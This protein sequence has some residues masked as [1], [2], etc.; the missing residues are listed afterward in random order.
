MKFPALMSLCSSSLGG[1]NI[2]SHSELE[3]NL[4]SPPMTLARHS[5]Y[6]YVV[7]YFGPQNSICFQ[8]LCLQHPTA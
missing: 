7:C 6:H 8:L 2:F 4:H 1:E 5:Q 3:L